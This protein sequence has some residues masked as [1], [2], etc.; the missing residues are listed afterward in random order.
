MPKD[1][2]E[3]KDQVKESQSKSKK[4]HIQKRRKIRKI[5]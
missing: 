4:A 5:F 2:T 3:N 1:N